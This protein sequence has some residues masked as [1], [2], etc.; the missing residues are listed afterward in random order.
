MS[1]LVVLKTFNSRIEAE[2]DKNKL[3]SE[4]ILCYIEADDGGGVIP[5]LLNGT[6]FVKLIVKN[7]DYKKALKLLE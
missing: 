6:G 2:V 4:N 3:D 1:D 7:E 5:Y